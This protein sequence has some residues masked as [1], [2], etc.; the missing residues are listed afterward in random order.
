[1]PVEQAG[2]ASTCEQAGSCTDDEQTF[3][4]ALSQILFYVKIAALSFLRSTK[5]DVFGQKAKPTMRT[6]TVLAGLFRSAAASDVH[7]DSD[8]LFGFLPDWPRW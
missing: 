4:F 8:I 1:M 3:S 2:Q 5:G 7:A 6:A